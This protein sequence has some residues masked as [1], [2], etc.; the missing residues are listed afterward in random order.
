MIKL[1]IR[2]VKPGEEANLRNWLAELNRRQDEV[3]E[4]FVQEGVRHEQAYLVRTSDGPIL[5]YAMEAA[6]HESAREAFQN[7]TLPI[8]EEHKR[9]MRQVLAEGTDAELLYECV[10]AV[11]A[12]ARHP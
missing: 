7:S 5:V 1:A 3:R 4:T 8:D 10:A 6:D 12:P 2:R 9:V 11:Q